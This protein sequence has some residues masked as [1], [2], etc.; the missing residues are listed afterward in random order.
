MADIRRVPFTELVERVQKE[1]VRDS[2]A[3]ESKYKGRINDFYTTEVPS[4]IDYRSIIKTGSVTLKADYNTGTVAL[5]LASTTVTGTDTVWTEATTDTFLF[6]AGGYDEVY[7]FTYV[8]GTGGTLDRAWVEATDTEETYSLFQDRYALSS[9]F[10]RL[11]T[12]PNKCVYYWEQGTKTYLTFMELDEFEGRQT[13]TVGTSSNYTIKWVNDDPYILVDPPPTEADTLHYKYIPSLARMTEYTTGT[14]TT[15]ANAS[16][17]VTGD[18]TDFDGFVS[19]TTNYTY[20]FRLD[21]DGTGANSAWYKVASA[22]SNTSLTLST[23]YTGTAVAT[24]TLAFTIS[25]VSLLP[26]GLDLAILYGAAAMSAAEMDNDAQVK[27][28]DAKYRE[29]LNKFKAIE[30]SR[31][32]GHEQMTSVWMKPGVRR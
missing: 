29:T 25:K 20:Y 21:R 3:S 11:I 8:S 17:A 15:L 14:I 7:R 6:K 30:N 27:I 4:G 1:M 31:N 24:A 26:A 16:T 22:A 10:G 28:W 9:D 32:Y 18:S 23:V 5:T 13:N 12:D 2:S 19:D